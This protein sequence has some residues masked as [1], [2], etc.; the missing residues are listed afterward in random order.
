ME[1]VRDDASLSSAIVPLMRQ[2]LPVHAQ[3]EVCN[4][5][6][7]RVPFVEEANIVQE[8]V[9]GRR[10]EFAAG[11]R[12]AH[13]AM[14][15]LGLPLEPLL[16]SRD[17]TPIWPPGVVGSISHTSQIAFAAVTSQAHLQ[18]L[19][20]DVEEGG[21]LPRD[22]VAQV[23]TPSELKYLA[24][25]SAEVG[26]DAAK[27][28]FSAKEAFYKSYYPIRRRFLEFLDVAIVLHPAHS[29]FEIA[30]V[31]DRSLDEATISGRFGWALGHVFSIV[32]IHPEK[33]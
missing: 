32:T 22:I 1:G 14:R 29:S 4:V 3:G 8:A 15:R 2:L 19:G 17:R 5:T 13:S 31:N 33:Y 12:A 11:R 20:V 10:R 23:C 21:A 26:G 9:P 30:L 7:E 16:A 18:G 25:W 27:L 6:D 24:P 28:L